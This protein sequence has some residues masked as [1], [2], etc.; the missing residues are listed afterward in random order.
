MNG[1]KFPR[2][3]FLTMAW[4][5]MTGLAALSA[6]YI[7]LRFL[8]SRTEDNPFG[9]VIVAGAPD[10]FAPGSVTPFPEGRFYLIRA[11]DGGF[12]ALYRQ[13]THLAC[14]VLW[15]DGQFRC[16]CH[17]SAFAANGDVLNPPAPRPLVC[18]P[19]TIEGNRLRVDTGTLIERDHTRPTDFVYVE[20]QS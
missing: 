11:A 19:I 9:G 18:F 12:M 20:G 15:D 6:G 5:G 14:V 17:G 1:A 2:R 13:C 7:G 4:Q 3:D 16:P 10:E 8:N